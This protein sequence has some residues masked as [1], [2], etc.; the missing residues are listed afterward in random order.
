[1]SSQ[2]PICATVERLDVSRIEALSLGTHAI[3]PKK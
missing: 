3:S 2:R 1:L